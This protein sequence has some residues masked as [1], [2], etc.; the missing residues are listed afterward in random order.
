MAKVERIWVRF[1]TGDKQNAGTDGDI[2]LGIG[3]RE[4]MVDSSN[5]DFERG[6]D[7]YY[8]IG[9]P[10][11]IQNRAINDPRAPQITT[12]DIS[13]FPVYVR[14][15][16]KSRSDQWNLDIVWVGV[17]DPDSNRLDFYRNITISDGVREEGFWLGV[18]SG[19]VLY[20]HKTLSSKL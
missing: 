2:Y 8:D 1:Q 17:N 13:A 18:H 3:G 5:D 14:F 20:L 6:A 12:E 7:Q 19:L 16:P 4:F 15:A 10:A 11:T 9:Q